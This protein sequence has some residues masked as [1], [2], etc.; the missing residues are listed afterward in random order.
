MERNS[1]D[2]L[3]YIWTCIYMCINS[4]IYNILVVT[5]ATIHIWKGLNHLIFYPSC[6]SNSKPLPFIHLLYRYNAYQLCREMLCS[7]KIVLKWSLD[8]FEPYICTVTCERENNE[9]LR[10]IYTYFSDVCVCELICIYTLEPG[11]MKMMSGWDV[12]RLSVG[13]WF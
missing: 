8:E 2:F 9:W 6:I 1:D 5:C 13:F 12:F 10:S 4:F 3:R 11:R 7:L